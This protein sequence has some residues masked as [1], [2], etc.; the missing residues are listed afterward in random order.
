MRTVVAIPLA[1]ACAWPVAV[2]HADP[3]Q[4]PRCASAQLTPSLG[5]P[6]GAAGTTFYPLI[7]KNSGD[8]PCSMSGYPAVSFIA[9][10]DNHPVGVA[11]SQDAENIIGVVV[12]APGQSTSANL[13][14]VNAGNFPAD[15]NAL[16]VSGLQVS[17]PGEAD[18]IIVGHADTACASPAYPTLRVGPF[19]G[20]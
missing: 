12:I 15:C 20:A 14:I 9:G 18:P 19:T 3:V 11:A 8:A 6:D 2:A 17:L 7:L 13:G 4:V 10:S 1:A 16:P 5:P